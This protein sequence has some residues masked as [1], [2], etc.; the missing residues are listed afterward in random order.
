MSTDDSNARRARA[1]RPR[2]EPPAAVLCACGDTVAI[3]IDVAGH[4]ATLQLCQWCG[5]FWEIDGMPASR[6]AVHRLVPKSDALSAI[7]RRAGTGKTARRRTGRPRRC[8]SR[9]RGGE[10][11]GRR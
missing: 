10:G 11:R 1:T 2:P 4:V 8:P 7:W 9:V 6:Q 5:D 3:S